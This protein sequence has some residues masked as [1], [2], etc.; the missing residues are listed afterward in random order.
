MSRSV[1]YLNIDP[2]PDRFLVS[3]VERIAK[4]FF[5]RVVTNIAREPNFAKAVRWCWLKPETQYFF[6]LEDDW[7]MDRCFDVNELAG[8]LNRHKDLVCANLRA[9]ECDPQDARIN[10]HPGLFR[11]SEARLIAK[12]LDYKHN[13]ER[14]MRPLTETNPGGGKHG[15]LKGLQVPKYTI[16][17]DIGREW[18]ERVGWRKT[19]PITFNRWERA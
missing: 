15:N 3:E 17:N 1:L 13:P 12:V 8:H 9:C 2:I 18:L 5:G 11:T 7:E 19:F 16:L 14:Q 10:L 4:A 6:H